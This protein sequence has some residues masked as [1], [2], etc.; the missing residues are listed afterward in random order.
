[1]KYLA[2]ILFSRAAL[3]VIALVFQL[4]LLIGVIV[5]FQQYF[6]IFYVISMAISLAAVLW[7]VNNNMNPAYKIA[8][9]ITILIFPFFGG[10]FYFVFGGNRLSKRT[11]QKMNSIDAKTKE[12]LMPRKPIIE[13]MEDLNE[14]AAKQSAYIEKYSFYPPYRNTCSEYLPTGEIKFERLKEELVKA[15]RFIFLEYFIIGEGVMW[16]AILEILKEKVK[17]GVEVRVIYDDF[18]CVMTLPYGYDKKLEEMGIN[19]GVFNPMIPLLSPR[20]NNR[21]HRKIAVIDGCTGFTGGI[22]IADEYINVYERFGHWKDTA[23][24]I[25]G[26]AV[27]NLTAM[28]LSMWDYIKKTNE[29][30]SQ[31]ECSCSTCACIGSDGFIQPYAD[32]PLDNEA[33][34]ETVYTNLI[35]K[36][37]RYVYIM[38]PYLIIDYEMLKA[39]TSAAKSGVDIRIITPHKPDKWYVH[40]VTKSFY[41]PLIE[42]GVRICEY[43]PGFIHAKTFVSDELYGV[44]GSINM[45]FRSLYFHFECGVWIYGSGTVMDI[46]KDFLTTQ[47]ICREITIGD[48]TGIPWTRALLGAILRVFAPIM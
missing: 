46:K 3:L 47:E 2:K 11:K 31:Y 18:G 24:M 45:D 48:V 29:D 41:R 15:E 20:I 43:E 13:E 7:I 19:C 33:V 26:E 27:W 9:I 28:F 23:I 34:G 4:T 36:A 39:L 32:S 30:F 1:M 35:N 44:V 5:K 6:V 8:W 42:S 38:T 16:N 40:E 12:T 22:N 37:N 14:T 25:K 10:L 21:D 17:Q